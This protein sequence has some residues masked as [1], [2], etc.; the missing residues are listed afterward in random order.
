MAGY[1][2]VYNGVELCLFGFIY[3]VV[4]VYTR[5]RLVCGN[6]DNVKLIYFLKLGFLGHGGTSHTRKLAVKPEEIL[7]RNCCKGF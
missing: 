5:Y 3:H 7:E 2:I 4:F 1:N 6:L